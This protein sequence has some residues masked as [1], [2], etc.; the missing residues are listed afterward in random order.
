AAV[1]TL[2]VE[3][4]GRRVP[5]STLDGVSFGEVRTG[6]AASVRFHLVNETP[7]SATLNRLEVLGSTFRGPA[8]AAA[9]LR[10]APGA[11]ATFQ[12]EFAPSAP[13]PAEG[14]LMAGDRPVKLT[15]VGVAPPF[16]KPIVVLEPTTPGNNTSARLSV[17][18]GVASPSAGSGTLE[19][20][21]RNGGPDEAVQ[22]VSP[23]SG[24]R[25]EFRV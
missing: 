15:G 10:L 20:A 3:A 16:P 4:G 6:G 2:L 25:L 9:P 19:I 17:R 7:V 22:F 12:V 23:E 18:F 8:G 14:W 5:A 21:L 24:R 13:G 11:T 1:P